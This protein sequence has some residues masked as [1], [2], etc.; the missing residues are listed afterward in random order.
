MR[1]TIPNGTCFEYQ[2][3]RI[4]FDEKTRRGGYGLAHIPNHL[5]IHGVPEKTSAHR[6]MFYL[7]HRYM[8]EVVMHGCD[9][10]ACINPVHLSDGTYRENTADMLSKK[11]GRWDLYPG[12]R[13]VA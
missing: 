5:N 4:E 1:K 2:G 7:L 12:G 11:R 10:R 9:N 8:P 13:L 6:V 3:Q